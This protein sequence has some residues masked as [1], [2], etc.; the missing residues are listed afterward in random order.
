[1]T[2]AGGIIHE[3]FHSTRFSQQGGILEMVQL[4]V[5]LPAKD[6]LVKPRYQPIT[7][8]QIPEVTAPDGSTVRVISGSYNNTKGPA[9]TFSPINIFDVSVPSEGLFEVDIEDGHNCILVSR[10]GGFSVEDGDTGKSRDL[11]AE[12]VAI[13]NKDSGARVR[14]HAGKDS[15]NLLV[16]SGLPLDEPIAARGPFVM[17]TDLELRQAML[18]Y[19]NGRF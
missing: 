10:S 16:L 5:N 6:K 12:Q 3:E 19:Q 8:S 14:V 2:A 1:M 17:N 7:A 13:M 11:A 4:W 9:N 15:V 18:D